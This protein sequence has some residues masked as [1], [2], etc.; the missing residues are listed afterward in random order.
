MSLVTERPNKLHQMKHM[1][2]HEELTRHVIS[3]PLDLGFVLCTS[4]V[5]SQLQT[6]VSKIRFLLIIYVQQFIFK[7]MNYEFQTFLNTKLIEIPCHCF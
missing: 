4:T 2:K 3:V 7:N 6:T 1:A 5:G